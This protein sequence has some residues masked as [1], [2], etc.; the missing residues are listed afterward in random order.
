[1]M[2]ELLRTILIAAAGVLI[3]SCTPTIDQ[4]ESQIKKEI[5]IGSSKT[6]VIAFLESHSYEHSAYYKPELYYEKNKTI[7]ASTPRKSYGILTEGKIYMTLMFDQNDK[8]VNYKVEE[9]LT[10]L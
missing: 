9:I 10:G 5:P 4:I 2:R 6:Q 1:M 8:L 3:I 7:N